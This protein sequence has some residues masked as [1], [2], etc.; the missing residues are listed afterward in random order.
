MSDTLFDSPET[1]SPRLSWMRERGVRSHH[2]PH[3]ADSPWCAWFPNNDSN[4]IPEDPE[5]CGYG[6][7]EADAVV[8]LARIYQVKLWNE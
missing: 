8:S 1:P 3:C 4:G 2:A 6:E 5:L 7:T